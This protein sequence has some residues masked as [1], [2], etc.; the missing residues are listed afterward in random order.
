MRNYSGLK[1]KGK[2]GVHVF[3]DLQSEIE[4]VRK[5]AVRLGESL[6][7]QANQGQQTPAGDVPKAAPEE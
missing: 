6:K 3:S 2:E 7:P 4:L 5:S 1:Y